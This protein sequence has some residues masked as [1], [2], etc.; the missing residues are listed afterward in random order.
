MALRAIVEAVET[1]LA[2]LGFKTTEEVFDFEGI[3]SSVMDKSFRIDVRLVS[4]TYEAGNQ[5]NPIFEMDIYIAYRV[6]AGGSRRTKWKTALDDLEA[7]EVDLINAPS[8]RDLSCNPV[9]TLDREASTQKYLED[10]VIS[11]VTFTVDYL[12]DLNP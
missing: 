9:L 1:R 11:R 4:S 2:A 10:Y 5:A 12:R 8:I 6:P 3:P 7:I